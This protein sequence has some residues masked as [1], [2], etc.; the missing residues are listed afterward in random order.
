MRVTAILM[1]AVIFAAPTFAE[2]EASGPVFEPNTYRYGGTYTVVKSQ[3]A[4]QC[5]ATCGKDSRCKAWSFVDL[6]GASATQNACELKS[7]IGKTEPNPT[8]VSGISPRLEKAYQ[9]SPY[10]STSRLL[11]AS[12]PSAPSIRRTQAAANPAQ[13]LAGG[14]VIVRK[15]V[16][17]SPA[18]IRT[19][20]SK[21]V[22]LPTP[23]KVA[24]PT[25]PVTINSRP[26]VRPAPPAPAVITSAPKPAAPTPAPVSAKVEIKKVDQAQTV[27]AAPAPATSNVQFK[28]LK[29]SADGTYS[30]TVKAA[31]PASGRVVLTGPKG[32]DVAK[33]VHGRVV[34]KGDM[35]GA[36]SSGGVGETPAAPIPRNVP[37][38]AQT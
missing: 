12:A 3:S 34:L 26:A 8:S 19:G 5:S 36:N 10:H 31:A 22:V 29:R 4:A 33:A 21:T 28:P 1:A 37:V 30:P 25:A 17:S 35:A 38:S 27:A 32:D 13:S 16:P 9:P 7:A 6:P 2:K 18:T 15:A 14:T 23:K 11:G 24:A 20:T